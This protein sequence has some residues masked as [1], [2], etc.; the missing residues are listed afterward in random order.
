[1]RKYSHDSD[2]FLKN[3][4]VVWVLALAISYMNVFNIDL[5]Y[6]TL[7]DLLLPLKKSNLATLPVGDRGNNQYTY[8]KY[9]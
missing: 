1:M 9:K 8:N 6:A 4:W 5:L 3:V 7:L 2:P